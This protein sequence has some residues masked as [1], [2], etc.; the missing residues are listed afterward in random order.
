MIWVGTD[1]AVAALH[2]CIETGES[3]FPWLTLEQCCVVLISQAIGRRK[4]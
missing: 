2:E 1:D 4:D 3:C